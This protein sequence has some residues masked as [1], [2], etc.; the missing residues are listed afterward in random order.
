VALWRSVGASTARRAGVRA[1]GEH[2]APAATTSDA[3]APMD[4]Q[5][6]TGRA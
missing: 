2:A 4:R 3:S 1:G 5:F 6:A